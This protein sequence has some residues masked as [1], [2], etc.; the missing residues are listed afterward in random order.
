MNLLTFSSLRYIP[1]WNFCSY[2][3]SIFRFLRNHHTIFHSNCTILHSH[4]DY[5]R[6]PWMDLEIIIPS[7]VIQTDKDKY[8]NVILPI[9]GI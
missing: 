9:C 3:N 6:V 1:T 2:G 5:T 8:N 7:E 4:Q